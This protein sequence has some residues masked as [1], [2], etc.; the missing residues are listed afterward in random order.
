MKTQVAIIGAGPAGLMLA[1]LLHLAG[2]ESVIIEARSRG[3]VEGRIRAGVLE[4]GTV[5]LLSATG[6]G[7][8]MRREGLL[9]QGIEIGFAGK[10]HRI[11]MQ[12]LTG[13]AVMVYGQHEVVKDL[14]EARLHEGGEIVFEAGSVSIVGFDGASPLVRY[15]ADGMK[16]E[17]HCDYIAGCDGFHGVCRPSVP[18]NALTIYE[19]DYPFGWLG[20]LADAAP[21]QDELVYMNHTNGFALFSMRSPTVTRLYLQCDPSEDIAHWS[22]DRIWGELLCRFKCSDGWQPNVG[23]ITQKSITPMRSFVTEP[24]QFGRLF[25]AGD[26]AH[27]VPPTGAKGMNLAI[28]DVRVLARAL[29]DFYIGGSTA[30]LEHYSQ[31]CLRRIWKAQRFSWWMTSMLHQF[32]DANPFDRRRQIADLDYVTSSLIAA[33]SLAENYVGLPMDEPDQWNG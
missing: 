1:H 32:P 13:Q 11:D 31:I 18:A 26:A 5:D 6:V 19:R 23:R 9:H 29:V 7:E 25:L 17:I 2:I 14:I 8:R 15:E 12:Q 20:V 28:A 33:R 4:Q 24:M 27:I 30:R 3:Y 22:D 21:S 10:R 16:R